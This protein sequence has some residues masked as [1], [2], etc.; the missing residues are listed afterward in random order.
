VHVDVDVD[1]DGVY[2]LKMPGSNDSSYRLFNPAQLGAGRLRDSTAAIAGGG[3][4]DM[5]RRHR[6]T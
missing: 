5:A 6:G 1:V 4:L 2:H 3:W